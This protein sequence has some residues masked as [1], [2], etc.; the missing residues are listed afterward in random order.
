MKPVESEHLE[1][2][3]EYSETIRNTVVAFANGTGGTILVGVDDDGTTV[4]LKDVDGTGLRITNMMRHSIRP[5]VTLFTRCES[6]ERDGKTILR[7][8]VERGSGRPYY[9]AKKGLRPSGVYVRQG[10]SSVPASDARI[11]ELI[12]ENYGDVFESSRSLEQN[13]SFRSAD[14]AFKA[15]RVAFGPAQRKTLGLVADDGTYTNLALLLSDQCPFTTKIAVWGDDAKM[16]FRDRLETTGSILGQVDSAMAFL[17]R[18]NAE[19]SEYRGIRRIDRRDYPEEAV[20][21]ALLNAFVHRDYSLPDSNLASVFSDRLEILSIGGL[22]P[23][24][25]A[26]DFALGVSA[27]R[28][29]K[30]ANVFYRLGLIEAY[31]TGLLKIN[32]SYRDFAKPPRIDHAPHVFKITLFNRNA[33][34]T[35]GDAAASAPPPAASSRAE[36]ILALLAGK[37]TLTREDVQTRFGISAATAVR[38]LRKLV[39][40]GKIVKEGSGPRTI[41]RKCEK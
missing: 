16:A 14:A 5:D 38:D 40:A 29:R 8:R 4:G 37:G 28:N 10:A 15:A 20:R 26:N 36:A 31:G 25:D 13:L 30:L 12:R 22:V 9:I 21:E 34:A 6:I 7:V 2:K 11:R 23:W 24:F 19:S 18:W 35:A 17:G 39:A 41:Y 3:R 1:F 32:A 33:A 27:L